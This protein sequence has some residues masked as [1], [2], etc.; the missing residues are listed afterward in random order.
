MARQLGFGR[1]YIVRMTKKSIRWVFNLVPF[2]F[3]YIK[4]E[5]FSKRNLAKWDGTLGDICSAR[6]NEIFSH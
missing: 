1:E 5:H 2:Y 6:E 4:V 3:I